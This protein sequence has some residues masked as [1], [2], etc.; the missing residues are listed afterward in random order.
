MW[1]PDRATIKQAAKS[2]FGILACLSLCIFFILAGKDEDGLPGK[3]CFFIAGALAMLD[4]FAF[5]KW[6]RSVRQR[7]PEEQQLGTPG[8]T[9]LAV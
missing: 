5:A 6:I 8:I 4:I 2:W 3:M 9:L 7:Q 1:R